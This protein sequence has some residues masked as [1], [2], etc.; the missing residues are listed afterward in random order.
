M[1]DKE[2]HQLLIEKGIDN[3]VYTF[4]KKT[5]VKCAILCMRGVDEYILVC[6]ETI[7]EIELHSGD[8]IIKHSEDIYLK[9]FTRSCDETN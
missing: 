7:S 8:M 5:L 3:R 9:K 1:T 2:L 6:L 4:Y